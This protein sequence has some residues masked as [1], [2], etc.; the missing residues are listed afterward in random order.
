MYAHLFQGKCHKHSFRAMLWPG[1]T[2]TP[3]HSSHVSISAAHTV[4]VAYVDHYTFEMIG[5]D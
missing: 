2:H 5:P 4:I 1:P 3:Q